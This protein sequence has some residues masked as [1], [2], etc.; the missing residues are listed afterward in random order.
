MRAS[1]T[2]EQIARDEALSLKLIDDALKQSGA[3]AERLNAE[4]EII[5]KEA[6]KRRFEIEKKA[7]LNELKFSLAQIISDSA[8]A[9][10]NTL[11][12]VL[13]PFNIPLAAATGALAAGQILS[14]RDQLTFVSSQQFIGRRGGLIVGESHEGSNGGVPAM[15]EGGE[16][17]VNRA[18]VEKY[19]NI[20]ADLNSSTGGRRLAIDDSRIVQT[21]ASQ[22]QNT[23]PL[24]AFVLYNDIQNTE[25]LNSKITQLARL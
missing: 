15:L 3:N 17:V 16:F 25:K 1:L 13:P 6:A 4:R 5:Q 20:I 9:I 7:R 14:I 24:K 19:G 11:A 8:L 2:L 18:A 22:N 21:I 12:N 10:V 23:P